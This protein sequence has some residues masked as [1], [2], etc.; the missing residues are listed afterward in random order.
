MYILIV[1]SL[2]TTQ[3]SGW[4][5][6]GPVRPSQSSATTSFSS[7]ATPAKSNSKST[8]QTGEPGRTGR[9]RPAKKR[10]ADGDI[11]TSG[12]EGVASHTEKSN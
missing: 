11:S 3:K 2:T 4:V 5:Y 9:G 7:S 8:T 1:G 6:K 12:E 10:P